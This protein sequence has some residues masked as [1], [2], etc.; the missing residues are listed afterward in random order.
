MEATTPIDDPHTEN[1][2][3]VKLE[4]DLGP[5]VMSLFDDPN[6]TEIGT[7]PYQERIWI[8]DRAVGGKVLLE[9]YRPKS[10]V[11]SFLNRVAHQKGQT[12]THENPHLEANLPTGRFKGAR[13]AGEI[14][15]VVPA[16]SFTIRIPPLRPLELKS[17]VE[18]GSMT[19]SQFGTII[20]AIDERLNIFVIGGTNSG[21]TTLAMAILQEVS[22]RCP[23]HRIITIEDT[24]ELQVLSKFWCPLYT[25]PGAHY[26]ELLR[27]ALRMSPD[28]IVIGESRGKSIVELFDALLS[29][30][31]GGVST[32]HAS[33][34][35]KAL[36]RMMIY[37]RR[38]SDT[39]AHHYTIGDAV[40]LM[41]VMRKE[42]SLR[43]ITEMVRLHSYTD[44]DG[45]L[46]E[47]VM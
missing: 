8:D 5:E 18:G 11:R 10:Y 9:I 21:K 47:Q 24:P 14:E 7:D 17:Y 23:D 22:R 26:T 39:E 30:H 38:D 1:P 29:G 36:R 40:D 45:Y 12:L 44:R 25:Y 31:P 37:A 2:Y 28:R 33:S 13:L 27:M 19:E 42:G 41:I 35:E 6:I 34:V 16:P 15:P 3:V 32:F 20:Q 46:K 4:H 43:R